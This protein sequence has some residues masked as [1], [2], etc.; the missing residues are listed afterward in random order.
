MLNLIKEE[1]PAA[2]ATRHLTP[3]GLAVPGG[4]AIL[5]ATLDKRYPNIPEHVNL[6]LEPKLRPIRRQPSSTG[7]Q[8]PPGAEAGAARRDGVVRQ[9]G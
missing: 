8:T 4:D 9:V 1:S 5:I 7:F 6:L 3:D 2:K